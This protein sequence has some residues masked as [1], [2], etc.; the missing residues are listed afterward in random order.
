MPQE[1]DTEN[2]FTRAEKA[3]P[4]PPRATPD[5]DCTPADFGRYPA[6]CKAAAARKE[7]VLVAFDISPDGGAK[8]AR[9]VES[10]NSCFNE[11]ALATV[12]SFQ[13]ETSLDDSGNPQWR[14]NESTVLTF[15]TSE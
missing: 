3:S 8:N 1:P 6:R 12:E 14:W 7:E 2:G 4:N 13:C 5:Y 11:A 15:E 10:T 9:I